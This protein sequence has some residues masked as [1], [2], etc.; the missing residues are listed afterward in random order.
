VKA[1]AGLGK[2]DIAAL[3]KLLGRVK[4]GIPRRT[5]QPASGLGRATQIT[6]T[7]FRDAL[8]DTSSDT[9]IELST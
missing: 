9:A 4:A 7:T 8:G 6:E 2:K 5:T 1:F 3:H